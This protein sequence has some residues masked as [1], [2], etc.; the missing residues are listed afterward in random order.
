MK[1]LGIIRKI[2][3]L[4]RVVIP[5]E[6]CK[7]HGWEQGEPMEFFMEGNMLVLQSYEGERQRAEAIQ[8]LEKLRQI[9]MT[10]QEREELDSVMQFLMFG[11]L[12]DN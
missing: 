8:K 12:D 6:I 7:A 4:G 3:S 11:D 9:T 1:A 10:A 5:K 2:D